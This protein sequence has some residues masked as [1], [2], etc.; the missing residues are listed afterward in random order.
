MPRKPQITL[1]C[2]R[3]TKPFKASPSRLNHAAYCTPACREADKADRYVTLI[4][5]NC[6]KP[7]TKFHKYA[8][9]SNYCSFDCKI[10]GNAKKRSEAADIVVTCTECSKPF[11]TKYGVF[12]YHD[13]HLCK[14]CRNAPK[15]ITR[16]CESCGNTFETMPSRPRKYCNRKCQAEGSSGSR[17]SGQEVACA[18]C[19]KSIWKPTSRLREYERSFCDNKCFHAWDKEYKSTPAMLTRMRDRIVNGEFA[20]P[21]NLEDTVA[22]WLTAH[23]YTF[24]RQV[25]LSHY[26]IDFKIGNLYIEIN[27]CYWHGCATHYPELTKYQKNRTMRDKGLAGYCKKRNIPL[28][29]IWEHDIAKYAGGNLDNLRKHISGDLIG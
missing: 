7:Y 25:P 9:R 27:G 3:C 13:I 24:E 10:A 15:R 1:H 4:C 28:T 18:N 21:S 2:K 8:E 6:T 12:L 23:G 17:R 11:E 5:E 29:V 22:E 14:P 16:T 19:G 20:S 26:T